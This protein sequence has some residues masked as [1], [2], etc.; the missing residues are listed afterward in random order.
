MN[1]ECSCSVV[2][3]YTQTPTFLRCRCGNTYAVGTEPGDVLLVGPESNG[4][5]KPEA[6]CANRGEVLREMEGY[7]CGGRQVVDV[8]ACS[9]HGECTHR[10]TRAGKDKPKPCLG[11]EDWR[12]DLSSQ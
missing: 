4:T 1:F 2:F 5:W 6:P 12:V 3:T 9:V 8:F 11:C 10:N 7:C